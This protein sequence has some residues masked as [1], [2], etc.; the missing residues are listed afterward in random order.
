VK[1]K[2]TPRLKNKI[3][4][5]TVNDLINKLQELTEKQKN[6]PISAYDTEH[7]I[8]FNI[9]CIDKTLSDRIDLNLI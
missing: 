7:N 1:L 9:D 2:F 6:L 4:M 8:E 3:V 5:K